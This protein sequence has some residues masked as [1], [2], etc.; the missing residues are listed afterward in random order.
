[1]NP[2]PKFGKASSRPPKIGKGTKLFEQ[3]GSDICIIHKFK[4]ILLNDTRISKKNVFQ[5]QFYI[6]FIVLSL[7]LLNAY[8]K[9]LRNEEVHLRVISLLSPLY[10]KY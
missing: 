9:I 2:C 5:R 3:L 4:E 8:S 1:M 10:F 6:F 7:A